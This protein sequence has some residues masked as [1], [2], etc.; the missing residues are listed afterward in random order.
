MWL[1]RK[2]SLNLM[3][4]IL[5]RQEF[6]PALNETCIW[7]LTLRAYQT[8]HCFRHGANRHCTYSGIEPE[9]LMAWESHRDLHKAFCPCTGLTKPNP[10]LLPLTKLSIL[11]TPLIRSQIVLFQPSTQKH[12]YVYIVWR[13]SDVASSDSDVIIIQF[14]GFYYSW[15]FSGATNIDAM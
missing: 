7:H 8:A 3:K 4:L 12:T 2:T 13:I 11:L 14:T 9:L 15:L 10:Y 5:W 1:L 6:T